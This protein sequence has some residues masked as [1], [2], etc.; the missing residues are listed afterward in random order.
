MQA[1]WQQLGQ[2]P[3]E[4]QVLLQE[5]V[6]QNDLL[7]SGHLAAFVTQGGYLSMQV[8]LTW[9]S[10]TMCPCKTFTTGLAKSQNDSGRIYCAVARPE[11]WLMHHTTLELLLC[12]CL[13]LV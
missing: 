9:L 11:G 3:S 10:L 7:G 12:T 2:Q 13:L 5:W 6:P 4:V 8:G 1:T